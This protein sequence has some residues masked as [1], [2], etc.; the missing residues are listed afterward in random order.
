V[1]HGSY[2]ADCQ[3][4]CVSRLIG[5]QPAFYHHRHYLDDCVPFTVS[6]HAFE[7]PHYAIEAEVQA[8]FPECVKGVPCLN[9]GQ[10][11][12]QVRREEMTVGYRHFL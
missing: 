7:C 2:P 10:Q 4:S 6:Y 8:G 11:E 3:L 5:D 12:L 1:E 9:Q